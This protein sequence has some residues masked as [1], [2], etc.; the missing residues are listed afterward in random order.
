MPERIDVGAYGG[1]G[2]EIHVMTMRAV[3]SA[4]PPASR[5]NPNRAVCCNFPTIPDE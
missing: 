4:V 2:V 1:F 5:A 3:P